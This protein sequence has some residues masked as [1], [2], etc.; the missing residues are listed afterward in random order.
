M[1]FCGNCGLRLLATGT[2]PD[3]ELVTEKGVTNQLGELVGA[4]LL[5][6]FRQA[7]LEAAGQHRQVTVLFVD[8]SGYTHLSEKINDSE[9]MY[10][11]VQRCTKMF[12]NDV[13]KYDG[14]VDKFTGDGLMAL[15]GAPIA[16]EN[17][18]E[19]AIRA[20]LDMQTNLEKLSA[21]LKDRLGSELKAHI[22]L[23]SGSVVVGGVGSNMMMNYTAIGDV[24]NLASRIENAASSG[25]ILVSDVV[26]KQVRTLFDFEAVAP[27][28]LKGISQPVITHCVLGTKSKPGSVRGIEGLYAPMVGRDGELDRLQQAVNAMNSEK[29]G[30]F[31]IVLNVATHSQ[32]RME[33]VRDVTRLSR[34]QSSLYRLKTMILSLLSLWSVDRFQGGFSTQ[35][36]IGLRIKSKD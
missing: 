36:V 15:F 11:L 5:D 3:I 19:L 27:L 16:H 23:H 30:R 28:Q 4:D 12:A 31:I 1:R 33:T 32:S 9:Q 29:L 7:G 20:A 17:S 34:K 25:I 24:V 21:E 22:G 10:E 2:L 8:L 14:M 13:Y 35:G 26:Y 6:R 18:T